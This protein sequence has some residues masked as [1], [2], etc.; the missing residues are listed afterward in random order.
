MTGGLFEFVEG[1]AIAVESYRLALH[2]EVVMQDFQVLLTVV[3]TV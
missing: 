2:V 3:G 1:L